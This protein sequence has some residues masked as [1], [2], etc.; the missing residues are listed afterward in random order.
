MGRIIRK[1][2][3]MGRI[4]GVLRSFVSDETGFVKQQNSLALSWT[5][6]IM[7][8][9]AVMLGGPTASVANT[10]PDGPH[11]H[12]GPCVTNA[13][14][15]YTWCLV[16]GHNVGECWSLGGPCRCYNN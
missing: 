13:G 6:S 2:K 1:E 7:I 9:A 8:A 5:A 15:K 4:I 3:P 12:G 16:N 10:P 11:R 14:C